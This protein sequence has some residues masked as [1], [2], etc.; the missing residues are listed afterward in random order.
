MSLNTLKEP[1]FY[2]DPD[3][4]SGCSHRFIEMAFF[5]EELSAYTTPGGQTLEALQTR[6]PGLKVGDFDE[7]MLANEMFYREQAV[8][9]IDEPT[10]IEALECLPPLDWV[11]KGYAESFK[12]SE[13]ITGNTTWIYCRHGERFFRFYGDVR[14]SWST[15]IGRLEEGIRV[16]DEAKA[17]VGQQT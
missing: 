14:S 16:I 5:N 9:E 17:E 7:V 3:P 4:V 1:V 8:C 15:I 13:R 10:Y 2:L 12:M 11:R 6:Y